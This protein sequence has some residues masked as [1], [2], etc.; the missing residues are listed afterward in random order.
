MVRVVSSGRFH[1]FHVI[2]VPLEYVPTV[3]PYS[4]HVIVN[5][6]V[7][8]KVKSAHNINV[9]FNDFQSMLLQDLFHFSNQINNMK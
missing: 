5:G 3:S 6:F 2:F 4:A 7:L 1:A 8:S 9:L